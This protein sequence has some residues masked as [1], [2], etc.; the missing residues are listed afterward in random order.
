MLADASEPVGGSPDDH[1]AFIRTEIAQ[2]RDV[3]KQAEGRLTPPLRQRVFAALSALQTDQFGQDHV[4]LGQYAGRIDMA[5]P[6]DA[7]RIDQRDRA[8]RKAGVGIENAKRLC[9]LAVRIK[10]RQEGMTDA[11]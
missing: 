1:A 8:Q 6:D 7:L 4:R 10:I 9:R 5:G 11:A 3:V 2:W